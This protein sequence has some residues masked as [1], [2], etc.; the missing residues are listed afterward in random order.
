MKRSDLIKLLS[1]CVLPFFGCSTTKNAVVY[2]TDD[3]DFFVA[4]KSIQLTEIENSTEANAEKFFQSRAKALQSLLEGQI[5][6][7]VGDVLTRKECTLE[8]LPPAKNS[9]TSDSK[10]S[11]WHMYSSSSRVLGSC[12]NFETALRTQYMLLHCKSAR[13]TFIIRHFYDKNIPW[14]TRPTAK[15]RKSNS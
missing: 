11:L 13:K 2:Q 14:R 9:N 4:K 7:Y 15:C 10:T 8:A 1:F 5:D 6:T 12:L 3:L